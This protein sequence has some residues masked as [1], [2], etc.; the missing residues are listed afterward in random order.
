MIFIKNGRL[1]FFTALWLSALLSACGGGG[2]NADDSAGTAPAS[3]VASGDGHRTTQGFALS[4]A[5][6]QQPTIPVCWV[7]PDATN[8]TERHWVQQTVR[9][10]WER[11][12]KVAFTGWGPCP[13]E[14]EGTA[15]RILIEDSEEAP[16][17]VQLGNRL[18]AFGKGMVLNFTFAH[19]GP[20][21]QTSSIIRQH[22]IESI[23]AHEFGHALGF[24]HEQ[25]RPDTPTATCLDAPSGP[26]GDTPVG[27]WD[28]Q[29]VMNYCNPNKNNAGVLSPTDVLMVQ[30]Y[31]GAPVT[32]PDF[33]FDAQFYLSLYPDLRNAFGTDQDAAWNHWNTFGLKE[34][35]RASMAFDAR[36]YL[37][38]HP[39]VA[40]AVGADNY[41]AA[42]DHWVSFGL[43]EGRRGSREVESRH[44]L[45]TYPDL[46]NAFGGDN[47]RGALTHWS[48]YGLKE[49]RHASSEFDVNA[50]FSRYPDLQDAYHY[51]DSYTTYANDY[52]LGFI[53][54]LT[55]GMAEGRNGQ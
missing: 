19:W 31:Y 40:Q 53:H 47:Y 25:N 45:D 41:E 48:Q 55:Y 27:N 9:R 23:A 32:D 39:D 43:A 14:N 1:S 10:T 22:C 50:Y 52:T 20:V 7:N 34:G 46:R 54:W 13:R 5:I 42:R 21:C 8:D 49:G 38:I 6:W 36:Y 30:T 15:I 44:Y 24:A 28:L 37:S 17:T 33:T 2:G 35:R 51:A 4:S 12:S 3:T 11:A 16:H 18:T 26:D 29:S